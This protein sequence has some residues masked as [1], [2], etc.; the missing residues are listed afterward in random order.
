MQ[1]VPA[2]SRYHHLPVLIYNMALILVDIP[3]VFYC[4]LVGDH[5]EIFITCDEDENQGFYKC[6]MA[7]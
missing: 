6:S 7:R 5:N 4:L 3:I 2:S 1:G